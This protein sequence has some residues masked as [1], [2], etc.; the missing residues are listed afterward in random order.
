MEINFCSKTSAIWQLIGYGILLLKIVLPIVIIVIGVVELSKCVVSGKDED[1]KNVFKKL[2]V[3]IVIAVAIFFIPTIT[4]LVFGLLKEATSTMENATTCFSCLL[5][6][7]REDCKS[8]VA[9][10]KANR[11][12]DKNDL[13]DRDYSGLTDKKDEKVEY[14]DENSMGNPSYDN[15][16]DDEE[17][18]EE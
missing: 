13:Y 6:P 16:S 18:D 3:K 2:L 5:A 12:R 1:I 4:R 9:E 14:K 11:E 8:K 15:I 17:E 10:A 7:L